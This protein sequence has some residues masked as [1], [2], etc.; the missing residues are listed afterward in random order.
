[1]CLLNRLQCSWAICGYCK[2]W[3]PERALWSD[4]AR[5]GLY[6]L[7]LG[8]KQDSLDESAKSGRKQS[9]VR[10]HKR[11]SLVYCATVLAFF[12]KWKEGYTRRLCVT[13]EYRKK[14]KKKVKKNYKNKKQKKASSPEQDLHPDW[15]H[16][17]GTMLYP[18]SCGELAM[19]G[20]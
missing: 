3:Q 12:L 9:K 19:N 5:F 18:L 16:F 15:D 2:D 14:W 1:M 6:A 13:F 11:I 20:E 17:R 4:L 8:K 7:V 10:N